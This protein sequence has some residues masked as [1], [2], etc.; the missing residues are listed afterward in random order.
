M[1][2]AGR[3]RAELFSMENYLENFYNIMKKIK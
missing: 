1:G 2:E 3:K